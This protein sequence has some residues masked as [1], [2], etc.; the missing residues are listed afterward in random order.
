M[1]S[2]LKDTNTR[3]RK[4]NEKSRLLFTSQENTILRKATSLFTAPT[5]SRL[6]SGKAQRPIFKG[7]IVNCKGGRINTEN[8][9]HITSSSVLCAQT[10]IR[11]PPGALHTTE[12]LDEPSRWL[13]KMQRLTNF[14]FLHQFAELTNQIGAVRFNH[15]RAL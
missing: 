13:A 2:K 14:R 11:R 3:E 9:T 4:I 15:G 5:S 8:N 6:A 1:K 12:Q 10:P 7:T